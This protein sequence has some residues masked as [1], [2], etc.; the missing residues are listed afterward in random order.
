MFIMLCNC[1]I[2]RLQQCKITLDTN[3]ILYVHWTDFTRAWKENITAVKLVVCWSAFL[4]ILRRKIKAQYI[5]NNGDSTKDKFWNKHYFSFHSTDAANAFLY[6]P[7]H[8]FISEQRARSNFHLLNPPIHC[9]FFLFERKSSW[10][11]CKQF[12]EEYLFHRFVIP[13][14]IFSYRGKILFDLL[15]RWGFSLMEK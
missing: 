9:W 3:I 1:S 10:K 4:I 14:Q 8:D 12:D 7:K 2:I 13:S 11:R 5:E 15:Q 6:L